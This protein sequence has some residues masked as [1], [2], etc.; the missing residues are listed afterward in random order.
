MFQRKTQAFYEQFW[1]ETEVKDPRRWST[2]LLVKDLIGNGERVLEV[3]PG[4]NPRVPLGDSWFIDESAR[5]VEKLKSSGGKAVVGQMEKIPFEKSFFDHV[6]AFE[7]LEHTEDDFLALKE[8]YRVLKPGGVFVFSVPL[9]RRFWSVADELAGHKRRYE[10]KELVEILLR[11]G[12]L[13]E[14]YWGAAN[15][16]SFLVFRKMADLGGRCFD[17][18]LIDAGVFYNRRV[19][20]V[21]FF[22]DKFLPKNWETDGS[23]KKIKRRDARM[24]AV[25]R[26][27]K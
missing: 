22:L 19:L 7:V 4:V 21:L 12:F 1:A 3:G 17:S 15:L 16:F 5:A 13:I 8:V 6:F 27:E 11:A 2:W 18:K 26:R 24:M 20:P 14:R 25:C 23:F 9:Q 10:K